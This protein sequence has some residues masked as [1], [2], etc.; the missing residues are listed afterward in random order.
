MSLFDNA[1][2][3][4]QFVD[5]LPFGAYI[6]DPSRKILYWNRR[7]EQITGFLAQEVVGH[8]CSQDILEHCTHGGA[9]VCDSEH[10]PLLRVVREGRPTE[11][12]LSLRHK[13]GHRV[14]VLVRALPLRDEQGRLSSVAEIFQ[15]ET[16]GPSGLC[17]IT[18]NIDRFDAQMGL[19]SVAASRAQLQ[20]SLS[21]DDARS[22][23]FVIELDRL[24]EMAVRRGREMTNVAV[25][26]LGQTLS[27]MLTMPHYL[28]GWTD[29]RLLAVVPHCN[30]KR[31]ESIVRMLE[32]AAS[33]CDVMWWG[34]RVPLRAVVRCTLLE[35]HETLDS[36][37]ARLEATRT[38]EK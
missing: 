27:R 32:E 25:R 26:A 36:T 29:S 11:S 22:A 28:G 35:T 17:F 31:M 10:C 5:L 18:E 37:L 38:G 30:Q 16:V 7:A 19:P 15:E 1:E 8:S 2:V 6:A 20:M 21:R 23:V 3:F 12:R 9:G 24:Q 13:A 34:E 14:P 33:T 4:R